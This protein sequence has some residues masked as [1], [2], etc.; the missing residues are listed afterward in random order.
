ME[1]SK[2]GL[3]LIQLKSTVK[4]DFGEK[5]FGE[6]SELE[7][8]LSENFSANGFVIVYLDYKVLIRK[9]ENGKIIL[10]EEEPFNPE[11]IQ[12]LRLFNNM[13]ELF[14]WRTGGKW[15]AR[16]RTDEEGAD[17]YVVEANQ[18]LFGT[19]S[20][21]I[22]KGFTKLTEDRGTEIILPFKD[23]DFSKEFKKNERNRLKIKTRN[24]IYYNEFGQAGY[25]DCRIVEFTFGQENEIIGGKEN[26]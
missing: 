5:V 7:K 4:N 24:Y 1:K 17:V 16:L 18:L 26:G 23:K 25:A 20:E 8:F 11:F 14:I 19:K 3:K 6:F 21:D 12:K 15:N 13:Q 9:F 22:G 2:N 10:S